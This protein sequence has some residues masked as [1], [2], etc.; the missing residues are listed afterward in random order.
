MNHYRDRNP[1][2]PARWPARR[3]VLVSFTPRT[4]AKERTT[5][6]LPSIDIQADVDA[7]NAG[8]AAYDRTR[9]QY[10]INGRVWEQE[11]NGTLFPVIGD[12]F[13]GPVGR[14]V[15]AAMRAYWRYNG[16]NDR[17]EHEID[18]QAISA[19]DREQARFLWREWSEAR[20]EPDHCD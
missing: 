2:V 16:I 14:G 6:I 8:R 13:F 7:I 17:A 1:R 9:Q 19:D 4:W 5:F 3:H 18:M 20:N 12:G 10:T 15:I 11:S